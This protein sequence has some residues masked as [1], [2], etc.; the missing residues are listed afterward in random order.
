MERSTGKGLSAGVG[1]LLLILACQEPKA[2]PA[3]SPLGPSPLRVEPAEAAV[4]AGQATDFKALTLAGERPAVT[5]EAPGGGVV[6]AAGHYT[7]PVTPGTYAVQAKAFGGRVASAT[8]KVVPPPRGPISAPATVRAGARDLRASV[9][10][11][12]GSSYRWTV[13]GGT[14][15]G[16][17][18]GSTVAFDAGTGAKVTLACRVV[19][20]AGL[21]MGA[22]LEIPLVTR[23]VLAVSPR[24]AVV[25]VGSTRKFGFSLEG[26]TTG[27]VAWSVT[28]GGTVDATGRYRAPEAPGDAVLQVVS[29][30]DP[31]V[32]DRAAV[33]IVPAPRGPVTGPARI[34][35][36][37]AA[38]RARVPDQP[39]CAYSWT[40]AGGV[41]SGAADG[42]SITFAAGSGPRV[43]LVCEITNEAG[44][45]LKVSLDVPVE[46]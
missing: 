6:N 32:K 44:D 30:E 7:A 14:F 23:V 20:A 5:W 38:L 10:E 41:I 42:P 15:T 46:P 17:A 34:R 37:A 39:G 22:S 8:V 3:V 36:Q 29:R 43:G 35:A 27:E 4:T 28:G 33:R 9:P 13:E 1:L 16:D 24:E 45:A 25:T 21:G 40:V 19:N 18:T 31:T 2:G 11:Q 26:G 12:P